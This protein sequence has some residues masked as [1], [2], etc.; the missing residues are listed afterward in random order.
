MPQLLTK[1][2]IAARL[3]GELIHIGSR[4]WPEQ[5]EDGYRFNAQSAISNSRPMKN[6]G[7][8]ESR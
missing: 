4:R 7:T 8:G 6:S 3:A 1:Y 2:W 5:S